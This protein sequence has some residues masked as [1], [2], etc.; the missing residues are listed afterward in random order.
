MHDVLAASL[1]FNSTQVLVTVIYIVL[2]RTLEPPLISLSSASDLLKCAHIN[3]NEIFQKKK[4]SCVILTNL[5]VKIWY[6]QLFKEKSKHISRLTA[7]LRDKRWNLSSHCQIHSFW[8]NIVL[9]NT[10]D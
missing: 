7:N 8:L 6:D 4:P 2:C 9:F 1:C 10:L 5:K 3:E